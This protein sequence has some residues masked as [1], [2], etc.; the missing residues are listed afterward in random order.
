MTADELGQKRV[1]LTDEIF[2]LRLKKATGRQESPTK[3][4]QAR[5]DLARVETVLRERELRG[6]GR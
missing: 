2:G 1:E 4:R 5:R 3:L 6:G